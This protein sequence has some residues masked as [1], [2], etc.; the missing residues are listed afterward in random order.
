MDNEVVEM[1]L[2]DHLAFNGDITVGTL[3]I[4]IV[5]THHKI[6]QG[7]VV[8]IYVVRKLILLENVQRK[9]VTMFS[10]SHSME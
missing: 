8:V 10:I 1:C 2:E 9:R 3:A 6:D 5:G 4:L 7:M